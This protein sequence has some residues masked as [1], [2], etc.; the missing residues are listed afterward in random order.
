VLPPRNDDAAVDG[1]GLR[2]LSLR[3]PSGVLFAVGNRL[4]RVVYEES[5][6]AVVALCESR[7]ARALTSAGRLIDS[8]VVDTTELEALLGRKATDALASGRRVGLGLEHSRIGFV[9]FSYEWPPEMLYEAGLL[10]LELAEMLADDGLGL[11]DATPYNV[12]FRGPNPIFVDVLSIEI[13]DPRDVRWLPYGQFVRT[14]MLPLLVNRYFDVPLRLAFLGHRDGIEPED[15]YRL[16]GPLRRLLPPFL[17]LVSLPTWLGAMR[18]ENPAV[19]RPRLIE[20]PEKARFVFRGLLRHLRRSFVRLS[21]RPSRRSRWIDYESTRSYT[22]DQVTAKERFVEQALV[23]IRPSR[24]LDVGCNTGRFSVMSA[25]RG[26]QVVAIDADPVVVASVWREAAERKLDILPLVVDV[27]WPSPSLGWRNQ[28]R[29]SFLERARGAFDAVL[30]LAVVHHLMVA[31]GVPLSEI[32]ALASEL[33]TGHVIFEFV[34]PEDPMFQRLLRGREALYRDLSVETFERLLRRHF[35]VVRSTEI[36]E[37]RR[38]LYLLRK[39]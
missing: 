37:R 16:S 5:S 7:T 17:T 18:D 3:D 27:V 11:K 8:A 33:G 34:G 2:S 6:A 19:Y 39:K 25:L 20:N 26:A 31:G 24:V 13:R 14:F 21:P 28:E 22:A 38:W 35:D 23:D 36:V 1:V 29:A 12:L 10:T 32:V 4:V 30:M 15:A 9:S